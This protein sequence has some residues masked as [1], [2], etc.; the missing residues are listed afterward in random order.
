MNNSCKY[1]SSKQLGSYESN[2]WADELSGLR[3]VAKASGYSTSRFSLMDKAT[4]ELAG[5]TSVITRKAVDKAEFVK[6][7]EPGIDPLL[8]LSR[9]ALDLFLLIL[10][11]LI[12]TN[13]AKF[14]G[15]SVYLNHE[16][17][18][19]DFGYTKSPAVFTSARNEL[20]FREFIAPIAGKKYLYFI[21]PTRIYKGDR[22]KLSRELNNKSAKN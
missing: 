6:L 3:V 7:F 10:K 2:P 8:G 5:D 12:N 14:S 22:L 17:L 18:C 11:V 4:G 13:T 1:F 16:A 9:S 20:C 19:F 21:N 15:E